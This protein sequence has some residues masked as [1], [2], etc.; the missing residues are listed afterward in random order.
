M[1]HGL[2]A[3]LN[4]DDRRINIDSS[5]RCNL[6]CPGCHRTRTVNDQNRTWDIT[7]MPMEFFQS[8]VRPEN[9]ISTL[10]YNLTLSDPIY[11][12]VLIQQLEYVQHLAHRPKIVLSTNG[13]GRTVA[14][15]QKLATLLGPDDVVEFC[16]DGLQDTNHIYRVNAKWDSIITGIKTLRSAS[17]CKIGWRYIVFE[18]NYHQVDQARQPAKDLNLGRFHV[19]LG[20]GRTPDEMKLTSKNFDDIS[21]V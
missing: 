18:H 6:L 16:I 10:V 17:D 11:S 8:L 5:T 1:Y 4:S 21:Q 14:W 2:N 9:R 13:S 7:D 20:D 15:W 12:G 19:I 3:T